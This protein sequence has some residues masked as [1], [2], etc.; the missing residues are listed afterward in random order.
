[1]ALHLGPGPVFKFECLTA[2]RRWQHFAGRVVCIGLLLA[3]LTWVARDVAS[4]STGPVGLRELASAG[5]KFYL[6]ITITQLSL[7]L[8]IAPAVA[9]DSFCLDKARGSL[10]TL[11]TTDLSSR[12]IVLGKLLARYLFIVAYVACGLPVLAICFSLG[13]ISPEAA[14]GTFLVSLGVALVEGALALALSVWCSKTYEVLLVAYILTLLYLLLVPIT[15]T[16][17]PSPSWLA[18]LADWLQILNPFLLALRTDVTPPGIRPFLFAYFFF[19]CLI[20]SA[21]LILIAVVSLRPVVVRHGSASPRKNRSGRYRRSF[22]HSWLPG[23]SLDENPVL[24]REWQRRQPSRWI[25][26]VW[27]IYMGVGGIF[28]L[29]A[30]WLSLFNRGMNGIQPFVTAFLFSIGLLIVSVTSVTSL[31][32]ERLRGSLDV[33][34]TTPLSSLQIYWGK[35]WGGFQTVALLAILPTIVAAAPLISSVAGI[36]SLTHQPEAPL[37][38][39]LMPIVAFCYGGATVSLGLALAIRIRQAGRAMAA[40]VISYVAVT[41]GFLLTPLL[42]HRESYSCLG[43]SFMAAG[44]ITEQCDRGNSFDGNF[45]LAIIV[46]CLVYLLAG[47]VFTFLG[48]RAFDRCLGRMPERTERWS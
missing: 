27:Y 5:E 38:F 24:W 15:Q 18:E 48:C 32:E 39:L 25:R 33:L 41:V 31:Q 13:G 17:L 46:W 1:V 19:N 9:A 6:A 43:S 44:Y 4:R 16:L 22:L 36:R 3:A 40:A 45:L 47:L 42:L 8:L 23:P 10:L 26:L 12:E 37:D 34:L 7:L 28:A 14:F 11:L 2:S 20:V 29:Y 35:W 30:M 21:I